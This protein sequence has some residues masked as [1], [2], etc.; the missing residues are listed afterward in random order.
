MLGI[1]LNKKMMGKMGEMQQQMDA[2]K[3]KLNTIQVIGQSDNQLCK[4]VANGNRLIIEVSFNE[5]QYNS[6]SKE[7]IQ[8]AMIEASNRALEQ[9]ARVEQSEMSHAAMSMLPGL[10]G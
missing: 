7:E 6:A 9:A 2:I 4:V 5:S 8:K 1:L 10:G 3:E